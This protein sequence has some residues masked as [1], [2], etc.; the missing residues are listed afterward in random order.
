[1]L[2]SFKN[3]KIQRWIIPPTTLSPDF[4]R[5]SWP[6]AGREIYSLKMKSTFIKDLKSTTCIIQISMSELL[7][8]LGLC[9][10]KVYLKL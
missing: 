6:H 8:N 10:N 4:Y 9:E 3:R 7:L 1:M 5:F 2:A